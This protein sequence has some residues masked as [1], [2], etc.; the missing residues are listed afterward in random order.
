MD[1]DEEKGQG[2]GQEELIKEEQRPNATTQKD[3][4]A[5][6][7]GLN[8]WL[9]ISPKRLKII[10]ATVTA[11]SSIV[12]PLVTWW[13]PSTPP[14]TKA[15][16]MLSNIEVVYPGVSLRNYMQEPEVPQKARDA[17]NLSREDLQRVGHII[18]FDVQYWGLAGNPTSLRWSMY[19]ADTREPVEGLTNQ[20]GWPFAGGPPGHHDSSAREEIWVPSPQ[21]TSGPFLVKLMIFDDKR[22]AQLDSKEVTIDD[23]TQNRGTAKDATNSSRSK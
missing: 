18:Y 17:N 22:E 15:G 7:T 2:P 3:V 12:I 9:K 8:K 21:Y 16:A 19:K 23:E 14:P 1:T 5:Q 20:R 11:I 13:H 4:K 6:P 10:G